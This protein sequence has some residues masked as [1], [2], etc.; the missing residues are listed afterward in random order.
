M[1]LA[2]SPL[3]AATGRAGAAGSCRALLA[4]LLPVD[5]ELVSSPGAVAL[6][7]GMGLWVALGFALFPAARG[8]AGAAARGA[9]PGRRA[10]VPPRGRSLAAGSRRRRSRPAPSYSPALQVGS[11]RQ[12]AV[13]A[14][15]VAVALLVL[16]GASWA[17][18]PRRPPLAPGRLAVRLAPGPRAICTARPIRPSP[19][20]SPSASAPS[21]SGRCSWCST[22]CSGPA[23]DHRRPGAAQPGAVRHPARPARTVRRS[24]PR[25]GL[26]ASEPVPIVPMRI[27]SMKGR[28]VQRRPP[29]STPAEESA[30]RWAAPPRVPLHLSRLAGG[31]RTAGRRDLVDT[32]PAGR[33]RQISMER[34]LAPRARRRGRRRD[35]LGRAGSAAHRPGW[36]ACARS[37][38]PASSPT[39]SWSSRPGA[40]EAAPQTLVTLTRIEGPAERGALQRRLAERLPNVTTLDLSMVQ[41]ALERLVDRVVLAIRFMALFT[42]GTG[43]L[44]LV[45]AL[46]TSRFQRIREGALLRTLGATRSQIFRIVLAEYFALGAARRRGRRGA[47]RWPRPGRWRG[48]SSRAAS[49]LPAPPL[50]GIGVGVVAS[51]SRW[52]W[53]TAARS[54]A[55]RRWR[56]CAG[57]RAVSSDLPMLSIDLSGKRAL[58][59]GVSDDGGFGF[60]IAKALA[61]AGRH[62]LPGQ[63][64]AGAGHLHQAAGAREDRRVAAAV[65]RPASSSS[66]GSIRSTP[67][68]TP[69]PTCPPRSARTSATRT[70]A[71]SRIQ[72]LTER[73]RQDFGEGGLDI[74]VHSLANAPEVKSPLVDTCAPAT[75]RAVERERVQQRRAG[76]EPRA[77]DAART[78]P[79]SR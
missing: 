19:W 8:P 73:L 68:S 36:P 76:A 9:T 69:W 18:G 14:G 63:L 2:G 10:R 54:S 57:S 29:R 59:A 6:G 34:D 28:P 62:D 5:V 70:R 50:A 67:P 24:S 46:A 20:C 37:T 15:G 66:S 39:S 51:P 48:G 65:R 12:G 31:L 30:A 45:G 53:P 74:V 77:A 11:W 22:T 1:A 16:W 38:G 60:A 3:G 23:P 21:C 52:G 25:A 55:E 49:T 13:F 42:L 58:V 4:G 75:S 78:A 41:E 43:T 61:E 79:S 17:A 33:A 64:A 44:V 72:G 32:R 71:T 56:C 35:R 7:L 47:R 27:A 26:R 40:L